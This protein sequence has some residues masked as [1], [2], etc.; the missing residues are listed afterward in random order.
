[1]SIKI[2]FYWLRYIMTIW[3][4]TIKYTKCI[5][6]WCMSFCNWGILICFISSFYTYSTFCKCWIFGYCNLWFY[7]LWLLIYLIILIKLIIYFL[8][9]WIC[10]LS[11][12]IIW[13]F[14]WVN[15]WCL[16]LVIK[17]RI[18]IYFFLGRI[19]IIRRIFN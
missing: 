7:F 9:P 16:W 8:W 1:M 19:I 2:L 15:I 6:C 5:F 3:T 13:C 10:I 14:N 12:L 18:L 17:I 11:I 4:M